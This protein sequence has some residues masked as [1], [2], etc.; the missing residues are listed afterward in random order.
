MSCCNQGNRN[1][2]CYRYT[3]CNLGT[4]HVWLT[5]YNCNSSNNVFRKRMNRQYR[6]PG[7]HVSVLIRRV[8]HE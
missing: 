7:L 3:I 8:L 6:V 1:H 4:E 2:S 5:R